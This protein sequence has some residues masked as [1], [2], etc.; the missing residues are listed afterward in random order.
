MKKQIKRI[1]SCVVFSALLILTVGKCAD[2]LEYKEARKKY[3][4][5]FESTTNF[6]VLLLGSSHMYNHILPMELWSRYGIS[7]YNWGYSNCTPAENYY[8]I[9]DIL[10]YT[11]PK[12]VVMDLYGLVEY[13]NYGN[14]K[15]NSDKIEQQHIQ[16][17]EIP[18]SK[19][20]IAASRDVFD[21]YEHNKDFIW[22]FI[23]YHN[24]WLELDKNDF[25][26]KI[27]TE[28][29]SRFLVG[30]GKKKFQP[31]P[32]DK[33]TE[34]ESVCSS[35]FLKTLEYCEDKGIDV[36]CV[37]LPFPA[38]EPQQRVA[39]SVGDMITNYPRCD[40]VNLLDKNI[41]NFTTDIYSDNSHLN[42]SGAL[43]ATDWLGSYLTKEYDL[44]DYL[45]DESWKQD[46]LA[47]YNYKESVIK[48]QTVLVNY[49]IM[50]K[51]TDFSADIEI[52][53]KEL[54]GSD[55]LKE[56]FKN[57]DIEPVFLE[58]DT[59]N[60]AKINIISKVSGKLVEEAYFTCEDTKNMDITKIVKKE[61]T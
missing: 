51:D 30:L 58:K 28:K 61:G 36:L 33:K 3:R 42:F 25:D 21:D 16:F 35:Y 46:Y 37:Y 14:G 7:S 20:K 48:K 18:L 22:N 12:V 52:Y 6:D 56:L 50:L 10:T 24:R 26:Y 15:Y 40:Y 19:N 31:I 5:F 47:Y 23:M 44:D 54:M 53:N 11:K 27:T 60:C 55:V 32:K 13:E 43:K 39:N 41:I 17:D 49:L 59:E 34:I 8:L 4:P 1:F 45:R 2:L 38:K 57:V 9:Q 29:G